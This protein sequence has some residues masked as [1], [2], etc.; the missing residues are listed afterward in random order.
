MKFKIILIL[1]VAVSSIFCVDSKIWQN[2]VLPLTVNADFDPDLRYY[3]AG[4]LVTVDLTFTL[5]EYHNSYSNDSR[6]DILY[7]PDIKSLMGQIKIISSDFDSLIVLNSLESHKNGQMIFRIMEPTD[8]FEVEFKAFEFIDQNLDLENKFTTGRIPMEH[9]QLSWYKNHTNRQFISF[10]NKGHET[11]YFD[12][13]FFKIYKSDRNLNE[14]HVYKQIDNEYTIMGID[15]N[16]DWIIVAHSFDMLVDENGN[17]YY[18][19]QPIINDFDSIEFILSEYIEVNKNTKL[20]I[21]LR[22]DKGKDYY[23]LSDYTNSIVSDDANNPIIF[24]DNRFKMPVYYSN[25]LFIF[26]DQDEP[27]LRYF[28]DSKFI[29]DE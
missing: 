15:F 8:F 29:V 1:F 10:I 3:P 5:D 14:P 20:M 6:I 7:N 24:E 25:D 26:F 18:L 11:S 13:D 28:V 27:I 23:L 17:E 21:S 22:E 19:I 9:P 16:S 2:S 12:S 4:S